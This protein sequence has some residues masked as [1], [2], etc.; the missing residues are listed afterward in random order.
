MQFYEALHLSWRHESGKESMIG[1]TK[2]DEQSH[3]GSPRTPGN[4]RLILAGH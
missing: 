3:W 1:D 2:L 4:R